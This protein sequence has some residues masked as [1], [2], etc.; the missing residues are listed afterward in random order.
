MEELRSNS[1]WMITEI[2]WFRMHWSHIYGRPPW[3]RYGS[4]PLSTLTVMVVVS[5]YPYCNRKNR[6]LCSPCISVATLDNFW[7]CNCGST[8]K[9]GLIRF[10]YGPERIST[11]WPG[12]VRFATVVGSVANLC[13]CSI[14][15]RIAT[16]IQM[17]IFIVFY[18]RTTTNYY[19]LKYGDLL[20][21]NNTCSY[22][23]CRNET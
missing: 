5:S 19:G 4:V 11:V 17:Y 21:T 1:S 16:Y 2:K 15:S 9:I 13:A 6:S 23:R 22:R 3:K 20:T 14:L 18:A 10:S 8:N 12:P 7:T